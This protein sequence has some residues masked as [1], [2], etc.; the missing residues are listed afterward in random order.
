MVRRDEFPGV[1]EPQGQ[2]LV[3]NPVEANQDEVLA[4][5]A[6]EAVAA[7]FAAIGIPAN[8]A[9]LGLPADRQAWAAEQALGIQRLI[10]NNPRPLDL[11]AME[12]LIKAAFEGD[13]RG[14]AVAERA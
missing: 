14:L 2:F 9:E 12:G 6:I 11:G 5:R 1:V 4:D 3:G 13:R 8:L 10:K 7:L